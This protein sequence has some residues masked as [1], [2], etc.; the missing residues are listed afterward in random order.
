[1]TEPPLTDQFDR[2][3]HACGCITAFDLALWR[4]ITLRAC[5]ADARLH[6]HWEAIQAPRNDE[7]P[8]TAAH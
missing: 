5:S 6:A 3:H 4:S 1:M 2:K 8:P 7:E